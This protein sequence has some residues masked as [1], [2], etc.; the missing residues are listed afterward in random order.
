M[1]IG[2]KRLYHSSD[3]SQ[4]MKTKMVLFTLFDG[5]VYWEEEGMQDKDQADICNLWS[6]EDQMMKSEWLN[7][8]SQIVVHPQFPKRL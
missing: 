3:F 2:A 8:L 1:I 7:Y 4:K 6:G 5:R